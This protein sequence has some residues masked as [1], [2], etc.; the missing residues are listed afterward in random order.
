[1]SKHGKY[2][3]DEVIRKLERKGLKAK[4]VKGTRTLAYF[5][6]PAYGAEVGIKCLGM[7][8]FLKTHIVRKARRERKT[9]DEPKKRVRA[10]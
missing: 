9:Y 6:A 7:I 2:D 4:Y 8:D 1:M 10:H 3:R 5:E